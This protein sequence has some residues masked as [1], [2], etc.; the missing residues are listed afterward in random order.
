MTG[1]NFRLY[2]EDRQQSALPGRR[3]GR[4]VDNSPMHLVVPFA[5]ALSSA[6]GQALSTL[7]LPNLERLL[8][9]LDP[10][11]RDEGD[12]LSLTPPHERAL[13][14]AW[15]WPDAPDGLRPFAALAAQR[16]GLGAAPDGQG[17][18]LLTP[19]HWHVGT[20]QISLG[21][22]ASLGL[23]AALSRLLFE[24][25]LPLFQ[26]DGWALLWGAPTRW[27]A[28]HPSLAT[29][30]SASLDRVIGRNVDLW[31]GDDPG[32]RRVRR[33][34]AEAQMLLY[35]HPL[36][37]AREA[38]GV[39]PV[40]SFWL[41]GT[42]A[43][44]ALPPAGVPQVDDRLRAPALAEDWTAWAEAWHALDAG[45]VAAALS[46]AEAGHDV[47]LTL[48]GERHAQTFAAADRPWWRRGLLAPRHRHA[49]PWLAAL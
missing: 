45:P 32:A 17:W 24:A 12:E 31:L 15:G 25:L 28:R 29:L 41:S 39:L 23:D 30:P 8:A 35:R 4:G 43:T 14:R 44:Q 5:S 3:G 36:N 34:Q 1:K 27:Y 26:E 2:R 9:R 22:P 6:A 11:E 18:A 20:E 38:E 42:G 46:E 10:V 48:S 47:R 37:E 16:D 21:D 33:L 13:A 19:A 49:A 40:N 7:Q